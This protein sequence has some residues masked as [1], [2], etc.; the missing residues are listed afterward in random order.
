MKIRLFVNNKKEE[1]KE[2]EKALVSKLR[3]NNHEIVT[4]NPDICISIGGDGTFLYMIHQM[5]FNTKVKY[6]GFNL[7]TLGFLTSFTSEDVDKFVKTL[8][9]EFYLDEFSFEDIEVKNINGIHKY[10]SLNEVVIR[11][12]INKSSRLD[13][14]CDKD[15]IEEFVGDAIVVA[16]SVGSSA[17][18]LNLGGPLIYDKSPCIILNSIAPIY[19]NVYSSFR[20]AIVF[21]KDKKI[22]IIPRKDTNI[23]L[24]IDGHMKNL[25]DVSEIYVTI[26]KKSLKIL[27]FNKVPFGEIINSK[28]I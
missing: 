28:L 2:F 24:I 17:Y 10:N 15:K 20:N 14:F 27:R 3:D 21:N 8:N 6:A 12:F 18:N 4:A 23:N 19:N 11:N 5:A 22:T 25:K 26:S 7:G 16:S 13:V 9:S 1:C